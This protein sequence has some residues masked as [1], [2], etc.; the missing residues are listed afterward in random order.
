[1]IAAP[2]NLADAGIV[3]GHVDGAHNTATQTLTGA[4]A[5]GST[6]IVYEWGAQIGTTTANP[7][8]GAWSFT[9]GHLS[10]GTHSFTAAATDGSGSLSPQSAA[11]VFDVDPSTYLI[12]TDNADTLNGIGDESISGLGGNDLIVAGAGRVTINGGAGDDTVLAGAG[13]ED[14]SGGPGV[15]TI[16]FANATQ[17]V[18]GGF[19]TMSGAAFENFYDFRNIIGSNYNDSISG[20]PGEQS[21]AGGGGDDALS[22]GYADH[23]TL[24][25]GAGSDVLGGAYNNDSLNGG[26]GNDTLSG[27]YGNDTLDGAS[28]NDSLISGEGNDRFIANGDGQKII[29]D[30]THGQDRVDV[31]KTAYTSLAALKPFLSQ[32]GANT[33][34]N[35][36]FGG[37]AATYTLKNVSLATLA[38]SDFL[39]HTPPAAP[40]GLA[41]AAVIGGFVNSSRDTASQA[42]T[43]TAAAGTTVTIYDGAAKLGTTTA[44]NVGIWSFTLGKLADGSHSVTAT[45]TDTAGVT[46]ASS[47]VL[48]FKVDTVAPGAPGG[49][50]DAGIVGGYVN[51][52]H[53]T[54]SQALTGTAEAGA[55]VAIYDGTTQLG[56]VLAGSTGAWSYTLGTLA[57]GGHSLTAKATDPAGNTGPSSAS[58]AFTVDITKPGAGIGHVGLGSTPSMITL[59]GVSEKGAAI[60]VSEAGTTLGSA[61]ADAS[62]A[63]SLTLSGLTNKLHTL[64]L[65]A[66]DLAGNKASAWPLLYNPLV[67][68]AI[69]GTAA[70]ERLFGR[71][72]DTLTGGGGGDRF[73]IGPN[74]GHEVITDF[75]PAT[76]SVAGDVLQIDPSRAA[77][78]S[79]LMNHAVQIGADVSITFIPGGSLLLQNLQ[80]SSLHAGD[81]LFS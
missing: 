72:G 73:I 77:S 55:T 23:A 76:G 36:T 48:A 69:V 50:A 47:V 74:P 40:S 9:L 18:H 26:G 49:L 24:S 63:W 67:N 71:P 14:I 61:V 58:L 81:F 41:D 45:A 43:G 46:G 80:L 62:G 7:T 66:T 32:N 4:A 54:A 68:S 75:T 20:G 13:H 12:G 17:A 21:I 34:L 27:F 53:D 16:S 52:A 31:S 78:F 60:V 28:G 42:L 10:V 44:N 70:A 2:Q 37:H 38:A 35:I 1:M 25:G 6:V 3:N 33:V 5:P 22:A 64:A 19:E 30:F 51:S 39:F 29:V 79:V 15:N 57:N 56:S 59:T 65:T 8:T 11:L